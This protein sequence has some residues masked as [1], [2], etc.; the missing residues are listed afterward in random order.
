MKE[1]IIGLDGGGSNLRIVVC[2]RDTY[3]ELYA[4]EVDTGT[5]LT[6]VADKDEA[7]NNVKKLIINGFLNLPE[8]YVV[9]GIGLSSAGTEI[10]ENLRILENILQESLEE[11]REKDIY[12]NIDDIKSFVTNDI[13]ILL[14]SADIA[15]VAGTGTVGA[16]KYKD[17]EPY[18]NTDEI[19]E[20]TI[21]KLD[22][23]GHHIGDK[24][25]GYWIAKEILTKVAEIENL[26]GYMDRHGKF[27]ECDPRES[28]LLEVVYDKIFEA[29]GID[30][31]EA[32]KLTKKGK[33]PEFVALVYKATNVNGQV[34]DRA[35]VGN[36][37]GKLALDAAYAGDPVANDVLEH[38]ADELFKNII[39]GYRIG[40]FEDREDPVK[41]LLSGSVLV[42]N[43][44]IR[45]HL[46]NRIRDAY[47]NAVI[48]VNREKPVLSTVR[49]VDN[50]LKPVQKEK[51]KC[52][53][54][55][56]EEVVR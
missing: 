25:S 31:E 4:E 33:L 44:I 12:R 22:G 38:A 1:A 27:V 56:E 40:K 53:V 30:K 26:G 42:K 39:A 34:F 13:D 10:P 47:P 35:T 23:N 48:K 41:I 24:G 45:W 14:T 21:Y 20:D 43:N 55:K 32:I 51:V 54:K 52:R 2:D 9:T 3:K 6:T 17:I 15:L 50:K 19:P 28:Y 18:D 46:E 8:E 37:F 16:V 29:N 5:N 49:Y 36:L 7:L 11:V